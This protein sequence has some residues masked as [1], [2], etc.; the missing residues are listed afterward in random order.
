MQRLRSLPATLSHL[1][2]QLRQTNA[3]NLKHLQG[4]KTACSCDIQSK[5]YRAWVFHGPACFA[6]G[7]DGIKSRI[8]CCISAAAA[9]LDSQDKSA[10]QADSKGGSITHKQSTGIKA[11]KAARVEIKKAAVDRAPA[12]ASRWHCLPQLNVTCVFLH[13]SNS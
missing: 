1:G 11:E 4:Q 2:D 13:R 12:P 5:T 6:S 10:Q 8:H 7:K 3:S 9:G